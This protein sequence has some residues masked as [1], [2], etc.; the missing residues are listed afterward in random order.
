MLA[1]C[2]HNERRLL[3]RRCRGASIMVSCGQVRRRGFDRRGMLVPV[4]VDARKGMA[5]R[6]KHDSAGSFFLADAALVAEVRS[7]AGCTARW[8]ILA[9]SRTGRGNPEG[10][11]RRDVSCAPADPGV[12]GAARP[13]SG[14]HPCYCA[15]VGRRPR[16]FRREGPG[17]MF[18]FLRRSAPK[19]PN[20]AVCR[21]L[22]QEGLPSGV[23]DPLML[24][25]VES[26]GRYVNRKVTYIRVFDPV[27]AAE[28]SLEV[29]S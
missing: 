27:R 7:E 1:E 10:P 8:R 3:E 9:I 6:V 11:R 25:V 18:S 29:R 12:D 14:H 2:S 13:A 20:A 15:R 16:P 5:G 22:E 26:R 23:S 24:R 28:R 4:S 19:S 17:T 21:A